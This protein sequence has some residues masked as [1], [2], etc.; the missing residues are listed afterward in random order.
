MAIA[1]CHVKI[2][3][4]LMLRGELLAKLFQLL[5]IT[6]SAQFDAVDLWLIAALPRPP[7]PPLPL[8]LPR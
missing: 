7:G 5:G 3:A 6:Y 4:L 1:A 8:A 2:D